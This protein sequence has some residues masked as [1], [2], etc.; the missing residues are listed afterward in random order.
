MYLFYT[1]PIKRSLIL[2]TYSIV[3]IKGGYGTNNKQERFSRRRIQTE[4]KRIDIFLDSARN[5]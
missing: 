1:T 3:E 4:T 2:F 5:D